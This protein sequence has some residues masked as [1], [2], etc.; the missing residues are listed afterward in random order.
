MHMKNYAHLILFSIFLTLIMFSALRDI[1]NYELDSY[2]F[3]R[4][5]GLLASIIFTVI[6]YLNI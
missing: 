3:W 5:F 2:N 4:G 6:K 1:T